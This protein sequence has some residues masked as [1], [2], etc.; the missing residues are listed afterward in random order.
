MIYKNMDKE[1]SILYSRFI[2]LSN[3]CQTKNQIV[4]TEFLNVYEQTIFQQ[5][6]EQNRYLQYVLAGGYELAERKVVCFL[7]VWETVETFLNFPF[8]VLHIFPKSSRFGQVCTHRDYLGALMS[9][10]LDRNR[11]GDIIV[12]EKEA[13][14]VCK[15]EIVDYVC[16]NLV[17][18]CHTNV[19]CQKS[20]FENLQVNFHYQTVTGTVA[21]LRLDCVIA[22]VFRLSRGK[23]IDA[24]RAE[25]IF[26]NGRIA[27]HPDYLVKE[28]DILSLRN[29]G[30]CKFISAGSRTRKGR[31]AVTLYKYM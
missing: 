11:F 17:Q 14:V 24:L 9:L 25:K 19:L 22:L 30:K 5:F 28:G 6:A 4:C 8:R 21:S 2:D 3:Q 10:G 20:D 13:F 7:P 31:E 29:H 16:E 18:V 26:V 12:N 1:A 23:V 27:S 15:E